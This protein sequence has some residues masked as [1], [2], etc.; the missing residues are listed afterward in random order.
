M[1]AA[2]Q[3]EN[4]WIPRDAGAHLSTGP[5]SDEGRNSP[6]QFAIRQFG[7]R[8]TPNKLGGET[9]TPLWMPAKDSMDRQVS[10]DRL[11]VLV[12]MQVD[13]LSQDSLRDRVLKLQ[14]MAASENW[15]G[16]GAVPLDQET[17]RYA[18]QFIDCLPT[19][20][21]EPDVDVSPHGMID[22][23]WILSREVM[24]SVSMCSNGTIAFAARFPEERM[25]SSTVWS[26]EE[27]PESLR[28][29]FSKLKR[30]YDAARS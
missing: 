10:T 22:F 12:H 24:L 4:N 15:D 26:K 13:H 30:E 20:L 11:L 7:H 27:I 29:A 17:V 25:R 16:E 19:E 1:N 23:E 18:T 14:E 2:C 28:V 8:G 21:S 6:K 9:I 3:V 5:F